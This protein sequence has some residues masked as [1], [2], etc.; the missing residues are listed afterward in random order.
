MFY[1]PNVLIHFQHEYFE[2]KQIFKKKSKKFVLISVLKIFL[3]K[4][5]RGKKSLKFFV[6]NIGAQKSE[7]FVL[8]NSC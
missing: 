3:L 2:H 8:K 1:D 4:I 6:K 5:F 7:N